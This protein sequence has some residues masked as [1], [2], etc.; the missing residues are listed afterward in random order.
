MPNI[1]RF[2][3]WNYLKKIINGITAYENS[4]SYSWNRLWEPIICWSFV[5]V[6]F[7][8]F[9]TNIS[10]LCQSNN[11]PSTTHNS[12]ICFTFYY[13]MILNHRFISVTIILTNIH[14]MYNVHTFILV[15]QSIFSFIHLSLRL[16]RT[17]QMQSFGQ[18][19]I[20]VFI[21]WL[22]NIR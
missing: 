13:F 11:Q 19:S 22:N 7:S 15:R 18:N 3:Y 6:G 10:F 5:L 9:R 14:D 17:P 12:Q 16:D 8:Y 1:Q 4:T 2:T 20:P 21:H